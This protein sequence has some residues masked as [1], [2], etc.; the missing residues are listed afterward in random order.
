MDNLILLVFFIYGKL[1]FCQNK[2]QIFTERHV[3]SNV[4]N[5]S[6]QNIFFF[7][8]PKR[9]KATRHREPRTLKSFINIRFGQGD[10]N[11]LNLDFGEVGA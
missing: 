5:F 3:M 1:F 2:Q 9:S 6:N 10:Y 7:V 8:V 4:K 11:D